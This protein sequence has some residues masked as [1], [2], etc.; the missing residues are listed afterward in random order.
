MDYGEAV[1]ELKESVSDPED[2]GFGEFKDRAEEKYS[3]DYAA[4]HVAG[5]NGKGS[6][7]HIIHEVLSQEYSVGL[8]TGPHM[9]SERDRFVVDGER[10]S[11]EEFVDVYQDVKDRDFSMF[12]TLVV[13][14]LE[15]FSR[16]EVDVA[17]MET[18][19]GGRRDAT[20]VVDSDVQVLTTVGRDHSEVLGDTVEEIAREKSGIVQEEG[21][22]VAAVEE[23]ALSVIR[24][25]ADERSAEVH[26]PGERVE[27]VSTNPL[28]VRYGG[29]VFRSGVR[30]SYQVENMNTALEAVR[31]LE[32]FDLPEDEVREALSE[33]SVPGR[34][35]K[36]DEDLFLDGAH[37]LSGVRQLVDSV[38]EFDAVVFGCVEGKP[39]GE[40][41]E[42]LSDVADRFV[43]TEAEKVDSLDPESFPGGEKVSDPLEAVDRARE[44]GRVL[45]TGSMYLVR[46]VRQE[47]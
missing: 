15:Y 41:L 38:G 45:V 30:G 1:E 22:V 43:F 44:H 14:A 4:V 10:I 36:V 25:E 21:S 31:R 3:Q 27:G 40:E 9:G 39:W 11:R 19:L 46:E 8:F 13:M 34:M 32:G 42:L 29:E 33:V 6:T 5:T 24:E 17:V 37:N 28:E 7:C 35:E 2:F 12:E 23:P 47:L 18:G 16:K 26:V 20:N